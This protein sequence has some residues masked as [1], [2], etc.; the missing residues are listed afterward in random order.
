[1]SSEIKLWHLAVEVPPAHT[2]ILVMSAEEDFGLRY[3][4]EYTPHIANWGHYA[5]YHNVIAWCA[6][7]DIH[8]CGVAVPEITD[9]IFQELR[10]NIYDYGQMPG[11]TRA[12]N[13]YIRYAANAERLLTLAKLAREVKCGRV[14]DFDDMLESLANNRKKLQKRIASFSRDFEQYAHDSGI[15]SDRAA[16]LEL[17]ESALE[18]LLDV[19]ELISDAE[20]C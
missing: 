4:V 18:S 1:M 14:G 20:S 5:H 7:L 15:Y 3:D 9:A 17:F 12:N 8:K 13:S 6:I 10:D 11:R 2:Q 19:E 16:K